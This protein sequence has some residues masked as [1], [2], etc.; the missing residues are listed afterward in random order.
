MIRFYI[1]PA[2]NDHGREN[3]Q[4]LKNVLRGDD[5]QFHDMT[6]IENYAVF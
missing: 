6:Q 5:L 2:G 3:A 4:E 1:T